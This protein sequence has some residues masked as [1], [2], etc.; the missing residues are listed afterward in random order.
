MALL[1]AR[2]RLRQASVGWLPSSDIDLADHPGPP[3]ARNAARAKA[4]NEAKAA[5]A[6]AAAAEKPAAKAAPAA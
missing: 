4:Q 3:E 5:K 2:L 1:P 6:K